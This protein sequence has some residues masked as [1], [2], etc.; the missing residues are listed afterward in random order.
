MKTKVLKPY[1]K[2]KAW[3]EEF[4]DQIHAFLAKAVR[5]QV[6]AQDLSQEVFHRMLRIERPELIRSPRAYLYR[7]AI[8]VLDEWR[9]RDERQQFQSLVDADDTQ[10]PEDI[11]EHR[12]R[13]HSV[14]DI[15]R[16]LQSLPPAYSAAL[17]LHWHYGMTY[18]EIASRLDVTQRM[19]KRY[20]V[21]GYGALRIWF[22]EK[23]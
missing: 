4:G 5:S 13:Q 6:D 1:S 19:V 16:A 17:I 23:G 12:E 22:N 11:Y 21:K 3:H 8:H 9:S 20:I 2:V 18:A 14:E 10:S 15:R 7:V